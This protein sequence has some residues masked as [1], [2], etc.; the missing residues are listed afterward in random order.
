MSFNPARTELVDA[1]AW[2]EAQSPGLGAE[3]VRAVDATL[4]RA[5]REPEA[6]AAVHGSIRRALVRRFPYGV[7]YHAITDEVVVLAVVHAR[8]N[9]RRWPGRPAR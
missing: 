4:Q 9:P 8:R 1:H 6:S 3:F 2:Y 7:F 5:L